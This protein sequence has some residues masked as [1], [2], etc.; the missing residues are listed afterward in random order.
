[1]PLPAAAPALASLRL[2]LVDDHVLFL[3]GLR[4]LLT[5]RGFTVVGVAQDGNEALQQARAL[6]PDV[7]L[8]DLQMPNCDGVAATRALKIELPDIKVVVLTFTADNDRVL[9]AL[10]NGAAGYLLKNLDI[11]EFCAL[12][13]RILQGEVSLAPAMTSQ[14]L[15]ELTEQATPGAPQP[16]VSVSLSPHQMEILRLLRQGLTYKEIALRVHLSERTVKYTP[17]GVNL[18]F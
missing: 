13:S 8:M 10:K 15:T 4:M 16:A 1:M 7:I 3:E 6:R 11:D 12:L 14:L 17:N 5:L 18:D 9:A 2:L